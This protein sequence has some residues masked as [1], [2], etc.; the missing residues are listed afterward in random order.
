MR[1]MTCFARG[2]KW[3]SRGVSPLLG[4]DRLVQALR[5]AAALEDAQAHVALGAGEER[6]PHVEAVVLVGGGVGAGDQ[7]REGG[8]TKA[9]RRLLKEGA[10]RADERVIGHNHG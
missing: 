3:G 6:E 1:K 4:L 10:A 7:G 2:G 5:P 8:P 9:E